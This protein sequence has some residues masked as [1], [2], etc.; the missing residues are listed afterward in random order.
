MRAY[1]QNGD[2]K[3]DIDPAELTAREFNPDETVLSEHHKQYPTLYSVHPDIVAELN[4]EI[5]SQEGYGESGEESALHRY[6]TALKKKAI[7]VRPDVDETIRYVDLWRFDID[8]D[9]EQVSSERGFTEMDTDTVNQRR[10]DV[11]G[12]VEND[13]HV[14]G[15]VHLYH[16]KR[17]RAPRNWEKLCL[18]NEVGVEP[19]WLMRN[20][21]ELEKL[22]KG[23]Q[24]SGCVS[25]A[26]F[27]ETTSVV[28][29][30]EFFDENDLYNCGIA[31]FSTFNSTY[32]EVN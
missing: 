5:V 12:L 15:E 24:R 20:F 17:T 18:L 4:L 29:L 16:G 7:E 13:L 32:R 21:D 10:A 8:V 31:D 23:L 2:S 19:V 3:L 27:P 6:G 9:V 30:D 28:T 11:I 25:Q 26:E 14:A 1:L 22:L